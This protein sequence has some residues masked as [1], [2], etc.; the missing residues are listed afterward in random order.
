MAVMKNPVGYFEIPVADLARATAFYEAVFS[1]A[2]ERTSIDGNEMALF[3]FEDGAPGATGALAQGTSYVPSAHGTRVYFRSEDIE[4]TL[5]RVEAAG[6]RVLY[7]KTSIGDLGW[8]AEF[9]D[10]EGNC[11]A[12]HE[13]A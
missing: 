4:A 10:S 2:L 6:G 3:G 1:C 11:V 5:R 7:P 12:L 9:E 8:V 13:N